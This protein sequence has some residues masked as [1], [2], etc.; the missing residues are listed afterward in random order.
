[1]EEEQIRK[2][3]EEAVRETLSVLGIAHKEPQEM[4]ADFLYIRRMRRGSEMV[5]Q[6]VMT[7]IITVMIPT[8]L[9]LLWEALRQVIGK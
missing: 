4:Q 8:T 3:V 7:S 6:R 2:I 1:M 5:S 9:Y